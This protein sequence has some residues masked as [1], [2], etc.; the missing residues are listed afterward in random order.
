MKIFRKKLRI[1]IFLF[2]LVLIAAFCFVG[3]VYYNALHETSVRIERGAI[4]NVIA[5]ESPV[6]YDDEKIPVG[7]LFEK[8]HRKYIYYED[9]PKSFIKALIAAEDGNFFKHKGF[10]LRG[11]LR[12]FVANIKAGKVVQ[13]GSTITQQTAKNIFKRERRSIKAKLRELIQAFLL[14]KE[15]TKEEIL[16][17]YTNQFFVNG[18]GKGLGIAAQYFFGKDPS[19]LNLVESAF[20]A[21]SVKG[22][23]RYN[24][25]IK[26]N[27]AAKKEAGK[28]ARARKDYVLSNMRRMNFISQG[29]YEKSIDKEVPFREGKITYGLNVILD[30]IREQLGSDYFKTRLQEQGVYN[31]A[32]SGISI[33]TSINKEIQDAALLS[34][35]NRLPLM[36]ISLN[37]YNPGQSG[38][39]NKEVFDKYPREPGDN[40]PFLCK[41]THINSNKDKCHLMVSWE[42]GGGIIDYEG[43]RPVGDAWLKWKEGGGAAFDRKHIPMFFRNFNIGDLVPVQLTTPTNN[44]EP[45]LMLSKIPELEGGI[46]A[47]HKGM[48]KAM[49]GGFQNRFFNR[50]IDAKRQ[51]GS[52]FK[53][54]VY[55][56]A[57]QLK[58]NTLDSLHN[59]PGV[60]QFENTLYVPRADHEPKSSEVS[61]LWAGAKS[62]NLATVWLLYHLTDHLNMSEFGQVMQIVGLD[63]KNGESYSEYQERIRDQHGVVVNDRALME[64]AFEEAKREVESDIIFGGDEDI[65]NNLRRLQYN[66]REG[67]DVEESKRRRIRRFSYKG[68]NELNQRMKGYSHGIFQLFEQGE[69]NHAPELFRFFY[70]T[71]GNRGNEKIIYTENAE[72]LSTTFQLVPVTQEWIRQRPVA[73]DIREVLIDG[74]ITSEALDYIRKNIETSYRRITSH[75]RYDPEVLWMIRDFRSLVNMSYVVYLSKKMGISTELAPVLSFPLGPNSI[76]ILEAALAYQTI[77]TGHVYPVDPELKLSIPIITKIVDREDEVLWKYEP[78]PVK[79]LSKRVS[80][81]VTEITRKVMETGTGRKAKDAVR[82]YDIPIP[83]FGKTGTSNRFTNSSFVG[84]IPG[85]NEET[86]QLD[87]DEGYVIACYV[88]YD[89]N[90]SMKGKHR[91]IY[92]ASGA[93]PLWIDTAGAITNT[94]NYRGDLQPADLAFNPVSSPSAGHMGLQRVRVSPITGLPITVDDSTIDTTDLPGVLAEVEGSGDIREFKRHFEPVTGEIK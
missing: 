61:M 30:H 66:I 1:F 90:R 70:R 3:F 32:T 77:M 49:V 72:L 88:G 91:T 52:I 29:Q 35:R 75:K 15:Y 33:H 69:L 94:H 39:M 23:N 44:G 87:T 50:T 54:I 26:K 7:V 46:I 2:L 65:L 60:F 38:D 92:G 16:E 40:F 9:I 57:L 80:A 6:Y 19:E 74:L 37:G 85:P 76:S 67:L 27:E 82:L 5:S 43:I 86:C 14:E 13:G 10:D 81:L 21:G 59:M 4:E 47:V 68:L 22:P 45:K 55:T 20:I 73:P 58:W 56:A 41:I 11:V 79:I 25:F 48:I 28:A 18:Y 64:A 34:L 42:K 89:D 31:V 8:T 71:K 63:R 62:E 17:M 36:D 51:L 83:S 84:F 12:A 24:P 93:L 53:P 78:K